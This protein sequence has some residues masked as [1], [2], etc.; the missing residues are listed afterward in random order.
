MNET[1]VDFA[2]AGQ[3][4][5]GS[6]FEPENAAARRHAGVVVLHGGAGPGPHERER[7]ERLTELGYAAFVP[8]LF[9]E[10]FETRQRGVQVITGLVS[11]PALLRSRLVAA[12]DC[13]R[14]QPS[15]DESR[16][17]AIGFCFGGLAALELARSGA[18]L[19]AAVSFHGG[20]L[21]R[22]PAETNAVS[23]SILVCAG[24]ADPFVTR[25]HRQAFEDE[26]VRANADWQLHV[27]ANAMHGFTERGTQRPGSAYQEAADERSWRAMQ[28]LLAHT[29]A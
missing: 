25:E 5:S 27:Y 9:G 29:L 23:A 15:V 17:A 22:A 6:I 8:D 16:I 11:D 14:T 13:L 19:R 1:K 24:V 18:R 26:M 21:T 20:L 12:L 4:F 28:T 2:S 3:R 7:A 10:V